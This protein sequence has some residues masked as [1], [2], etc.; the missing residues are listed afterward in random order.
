M[1]GAWGFGGCSARTQ[2]ATWGRGESGG[3][4]R[5]TW[6]RGGTIVAVRGQEEQRA[7]MWIFVRGPKREE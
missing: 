3:Q 2:R 1:V 7:V 5:G 4:E 6:V